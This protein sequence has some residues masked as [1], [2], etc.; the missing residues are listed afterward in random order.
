MSE[1]KHLLAGTADI[2]QIANHLD[3]LGHE[4]RL[5]QVRDLNSSQ[6]AALYDRADGCHLELEQLVAAD[7]PAGQEVVHHGI[8]SVP[9]VGGTFRKRMTRVAEGEAML[10]GYN[11]NDGFVA[12]VGW[13][14][15]PGYFVIRPR[16]CSNPDGRTDTEQLFVDYYEQP[17]AA[18]VAGW[19][20]PKPTIGLTASLVFGQMCDYM[21]RV[22][23]HV[24][25]GAAYKK[26]K[27]VGPHFALVRED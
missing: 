1:L 25:I 20:D 22:S 4:E 5:A 6:L 3:G 9:V 18:P 13:F 10:A 19:P 14:T 26:G 23:A 24:C 15:G 16:G 12:Q 7:V 27:A 11:D 8:N 2:D 21:W 17:A